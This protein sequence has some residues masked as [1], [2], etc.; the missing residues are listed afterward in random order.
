M[1]DAVAVLSSG[2]LDSCVLLADMARDATVYPIYIRNGLIWEKAERKALQAFVLALKNHN[3]QPI[4]TISLPFRSLYGDHWSLS[5]LGIPSQYDPDNTT[6]LPGRN[7][8]LLSLAAVWCSC[9]GVARIAVGTLKNNPFPDA[10]PLF[11]RQF[12]TTLSTVLGLPI[13]IEAPYREKYTKEDLIRTYHFLPLE[14]SCTCMAPTRGKHCGHCN[15]CYE[16]QKGYQ[17][18]GVPDR[19]QYATKQ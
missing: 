18:A 4:T 8:L 10:T 7:V 19:T 5:G 6:Y 2:G 12:G 11:F 3:V 13:Q 1:A 9:H 17:G 16:R 15:K 14:L